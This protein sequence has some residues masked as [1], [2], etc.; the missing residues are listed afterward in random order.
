MQTEPAAEPDTQVTQPEAKAEPEAPSKEE[1]EPVAAEDPRTEP[2][3]GL[4]VTIGVRSERAEP[5]EGKPAIE[6]V[7]ETRVTRVPRAERARKAYVE[8]GIA[9]AKDILDEPGPQ[10]PQELL[11]EVDFG[12]D[13][14]SEESFEVL[15]FPHDPIIKEYLEEER[16][17]ER[18]KGETTAASSSTGL[19]APPLYAAGI[20]RA[21]PTSSVEAELETALDLC[22][23]IQGVLSQQPEPPKPTV[24]Q[25][26]SEC[27]RPDTAADGGS[28]E[29]GASVNYRATESS[30][31]KR[32]AAA[33]EGRS[34]AAPQRRNDVIAGISHRRRSRSASPAQRGELRRRKTG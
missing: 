6:A 26:G 3:S 30:A 17:K 29:S 10:V 31:S 32:A 12:A 4:R 2:N 34:G 13:I 16:A 21:Q 20:P 24:Q 18:R 8:K 7:E 5:P 25:D 23:K 22:D 27:G 14:S 11:D 33:R 9:E 19:A 28:S 1:P 15:E